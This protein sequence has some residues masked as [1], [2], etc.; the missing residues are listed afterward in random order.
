MDI[1]KTFFTPPQGQHRGANGA[2]RGRAQ[3][4]NEEGKQPP[5]KDGPSGQLLPPQR[6]GPQNLPGRRAFQ[7]PWTGLSGWKTLLHH[8]L[9][10]RCSIVLPRQVPW[11]LGP[12][13]INVTSAVRLTRSLSFWAP[14]RLTWLRVQ[15][16]TIVYR[17]VQFKGK[18]KSYFNSNIIQKNQFNN[19]KMGAFVE[20]TEGVFWETLCDPLSL[21]PVFALSAPSMLIFIPSFCCLYMTHFYHFQM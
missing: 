14:E 6:K 2:F 5:A 18:C 15:L 20:K 3:W 13:W 10:A 19:I 1:N 21:S 7:R 12:R 11:R 17:T 16:C 4:I 8:F 9:S